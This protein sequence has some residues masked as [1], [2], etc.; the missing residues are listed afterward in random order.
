[1]KS[2]ELFTHALQMAA[3]PGNHRNQYGISETDGHVYQTESNGICLETDTKLNGLTLCCC[4][5]A[6]N[7]DSTNSIKN[8][9]FEKLECNGSCRVPSAEDVTEALKSRDLLLDN[10]TVCIN[11]L[12]TAILTACTVLR[13]GQVIKNV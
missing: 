11:A 1:M 10:F 4:K 9:C 12:K 13:I 7:K 8:M 5:F 6:V 3:L 2:C